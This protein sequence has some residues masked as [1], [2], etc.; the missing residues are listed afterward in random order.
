MAT[1]SGVWLT[2][3]VK[4]WLCEWMATECEVDI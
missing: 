1:V 3:R 4:S 2:Y